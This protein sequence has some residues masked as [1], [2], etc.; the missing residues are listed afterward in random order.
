MISPTPD[1]GVYLWV[2]GWDITGRLVD[3]DGIYPGMLVWQVEL[4][5]GTMDYVIVGYYAWTGNKPIPE[6]EYYGMLWT[7][8]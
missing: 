3:R 6:V 1:E 2:E 5:Y 4:G 7:T 8:P